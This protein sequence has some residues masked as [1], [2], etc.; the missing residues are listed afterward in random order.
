MIPA[1]QDSAQPPGLRRVPVGG[2][3]ALSTSFFSGFA[4]LFAIRPK[5]GTIPP[6]SAFARIILNWDFKHMAL[7][8]DANFSKN[9][10]FA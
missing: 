9:A 4:L 6:D 8:E 10:S 1:V 7:E 2:A 5:C 3:G